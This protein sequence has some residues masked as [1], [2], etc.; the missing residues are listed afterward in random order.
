[1][2]IWGANFSENDDAADWLIAYLESPNLL[3]LNEAFDVILN[4]DE[5]EYIDVTDGANC[6]IAA[7]IFLEILIPSSEAIRIKNIVDL[8]NLKST[9]I[10]MDKGAL[11]NMLKRAIKSV[12]IVA[13][14][15]DRS[16]L[17]ELMDEDHELLQPWL[18]NTASLIN[19]LTKKLQTM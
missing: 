7:S 4:V 15:E 19:N 8:N 5:E 6:L 14:L 1:M 9:L 11:R 10:K 13:D 12:N 18:T 2:S 17:R 3:L 16:E